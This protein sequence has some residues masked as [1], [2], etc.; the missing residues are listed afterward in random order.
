MRLTLEPLDL[1]TTFEFRIAVGGRKAYR[2]LLV[3]LEHDGIT[4][5]GEAA[6][7]F[8]YGESRELAEAAL[9]AWAPHLGDDPFALEAIEARLHGVLRGHGAAHA[10]LEMALHDWI[11][12]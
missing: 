10:A 8:Y 7:A 12:K 3:R 9:A 5:L 11:G 6:P 4:G 2:N 1:E